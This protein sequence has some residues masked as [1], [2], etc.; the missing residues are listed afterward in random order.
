MVAMADLT[1]S[2]SA[3]RVITSPKERMAPFRSASGM[4]PDRRVSISAVK[5]VMTA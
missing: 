5:A 4:G 1:P 3:R 2:I